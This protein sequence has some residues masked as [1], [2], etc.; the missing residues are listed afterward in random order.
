MGMLKRNGHAKVR[1]FDTLKCDGLCYLM[2][3]DKVRCLNMLKCDFPIRVEINK[4]DNA[5]YRQSDAV[6]ET[7]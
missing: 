2:E 3:H 6:Y 4:N 7:L 1:L 5:D